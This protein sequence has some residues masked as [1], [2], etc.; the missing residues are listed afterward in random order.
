[1]AINIRKDIAAEAVY[2]QAKQEK[3]AKVRTRLLAIAAVLE[4]KT[5]TYAA[6]LAGITI[7]N[8]RI[9]IK[10]FNEQGF[11]G[12]KSKKQWGRPTLW[13]NQVEEFL[14]AKVIQGACFETDN[15][16]TFRLEDLQVI[17]KKEF[18]LHYGISTI[19]YKLKQLGLSWI[20]VRQQHPKSNLELQEDFKKKFL[21]LSKSYKS[22][23]Q[24]KK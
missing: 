6:K 1:M 7:S 8:I 24:Q 10:R 11:E 2:R 12:L 15:R 18:D 20:S 3:S 19:W 23:T 9:W 16:V 22:S 4:G 13:T 21:K 17:L 5:K 14:K